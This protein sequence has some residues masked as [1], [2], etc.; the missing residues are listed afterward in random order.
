MVYQDNAHL[1]GP[2]GLLLA[3]NGD[4]ITANGGAVNPGGTQNDLVEFTRR[5][6]FVANF[7]VDSGAGGGSFAIAVRDRKAGFDSPLWTTIRT[8]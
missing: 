2:L 5:G 1:H 4:L 6:Q 7:Q 3:P 8:L